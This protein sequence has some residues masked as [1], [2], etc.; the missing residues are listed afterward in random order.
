M[1]VSCSSRVLFCQK[2][3][4]CGTVAGGNVFLHPAALVVEFRRGPRHA[5]QLRVLGQK[6]LFRGELVKKVTACILF[7][8]LGLALSV[9]AVAHADSNSAH[10]K[11]VK[12]SQ[13]SYKK[14]MKQQ[15]KSQK[16]AQKSQKKAMKAWKKNHGA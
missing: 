4:R 9:P 16:K 2:R 12:N 8:L 5:P 1:R 13:K 3:T 7:I 11:A 15:K 14:S 6:S 10:R